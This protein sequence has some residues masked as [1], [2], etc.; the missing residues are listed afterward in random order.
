V[1]VR[2]LGLVPARLAAASCRVRWPSSQVIECDCNALL[3]HCQTMQEQL[4]YLRITL[5]Q[6]PRWFGMWGVCHKA[7][8]VPAIGG[9]QPK[10]ARQGGCQLRQGLLGVTISNA[11][12]WH[13]RK[14]LVSYNPQQ[15]HTVWL[16]LRQFAAS[17][18]VLW[19]TARMQL[20][21]KK[22][23]ILMTLPKPVAVSSFAN[24]TISCSRGA[25][26]GWRGCPRSFHCTE[27]PGFKA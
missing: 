8:L 20:G 24:I 12:V 25:P 18:P 13:F 27:S 23:V 17:T 5:Q 3:M 1:L 26:A 22:T 4:R 19:H 7:W 16:C 15:K 14:Q 21:L 9:S 6:E 11:R 10:A 2:R